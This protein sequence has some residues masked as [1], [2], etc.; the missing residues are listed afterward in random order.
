MDASPPRQHV[1]ECVLEQ[2]GKH[3]HETHR[4]PEPIAHQVAESIH[5][6]PDVDRLYVGD[7][8]QRRVDER[9]L[10]RR[11]QHRQQA[12]DVSGQSAGRG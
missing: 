3:E 2:R 4:H 12:D 6:H 5:R 7:A 11:R 1:D 9:R 10:S 8:R